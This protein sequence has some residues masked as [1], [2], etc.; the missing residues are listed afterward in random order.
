MMNPR[1]FA[2]SGGGL[3]RDGRSRR[4]GR[5]LACRTSVR[6][7]SRTPAQCRS[8]TAAHRHSSLT[9]EVADAPQATALGNIDVASADAATV[10]ELVTGTD[11]GDGGPG[12]TEIVFGSTGADCRGRVARSVAGAAARDTARAGR[13][14]EHA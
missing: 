1:R 6:P 9:A 7:A 2:T 3:V 14:S 5:R 10:A 12:S 13:D 4:L 11:A 8:R